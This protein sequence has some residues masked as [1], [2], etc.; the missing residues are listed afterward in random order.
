MHRLATLF[1]TAAVTL[2]Q[3]TPRPATEFAIHRPGA[4]DLKLSAYRGK[5]VVLALLNSGCEH[6]Q[7]FAEQLATYQKDYGPG[8]VQVLAAVFDNGAKDQ[9]AKFR[10]KYVHG[11]PV[12]YSDEATAMK[13]LDSPLDKGYFVPIVAFIGRKGTIESQHMGDDNL[14]QNPDSNIR[15]ILDRLLKDTR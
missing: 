13:W 4:P 5:V 9:L 8:G 12:G 7:H 6:C 10:D 3:Q 1:L 2:A 15:H 14:F 11:F